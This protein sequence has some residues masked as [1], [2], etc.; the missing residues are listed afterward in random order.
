MDQRH[1]AKSIKLSER[2]IGLYLHNLGLGNGFLN[3]TP[4][5]QATKEKADKLDYIKTKNICTSK[6]T[7]KRV[8]TQP[9]EWEN[10]FANNLSDKGLISRIYKGPLQLSKRKSLKKTNN[11][12]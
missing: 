9:T 2:K 5:A 11:T 8:K 6:D 4:K 1:K 10:T 3:M 12:I 7:I